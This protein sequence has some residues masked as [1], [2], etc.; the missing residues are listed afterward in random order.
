MTPPPI[1]PPKLRPGTRSGSSPPPEPRPGH[2][3]RP[4]AADRG[5][6]RRDGTRAH[7]RRATSTSGTTSTPPPSP[8][9]RRPACRLRRPGGAGILTVIG[10]FNSNELLPYLDWDLIAGNPKVFCGYS[11]ITA[12]QNAILARTGL[13]TYSGPHWSTFGMRDHFERHLATGSGRPARA[14]SP[15]TSRPPRLDRR[16]VVPRP[17]RPTGPRPNEGWWTLQPGAGHRPARRRQPLHPEP[18][19]G[20]R[21]HAVPGRARCWSSRTTSSPTRSTFARDLTSLLQLPDAAGIRGLIVGR[22]Q[23]ASA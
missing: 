4:H 18:A 17:G 23:R 11:D 12:L 9:R 6:V 19:P 22:F 1:Y 16:P 13:V 10:G 5:P 8:P 21:V 20:H 3:A 2:G 14:T 7:L 15:S